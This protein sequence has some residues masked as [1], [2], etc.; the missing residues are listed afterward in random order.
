MKSKNPLR[1]TETSA[2][3]IAENYYLLN[4]F[5]YSNSFSYKT[6]R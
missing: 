2:A 6:T 4:F 3:R 1:E 5:S